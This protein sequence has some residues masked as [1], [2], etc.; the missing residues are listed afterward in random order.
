MEVIAGGGGVVH[1]WGRSRCHCERCVGLCTVRL[2]V[3]LCCAT[4]YRRHLS[5]APTR[6]L[7]RPRLQLLGG[8]ERHVYRLEG[9][10][11]RCVAAW[12]VTWPPVWLLLD[13]LSLVCVV[14]QMLVTWRLEATSRTSPSSS[15][16]FCWA[17]SRARWVW[18]CSAMLAAWSAVS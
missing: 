1:R 7:R 15:I 2:T 13:R 3:L 4:A 18:E 14:T 6:W 9:K 8:D 10:A 16:V 11:G 17:A 5:R 12:P